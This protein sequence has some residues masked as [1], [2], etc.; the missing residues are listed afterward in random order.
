MDTPRSKHE[1]GIALL[2]TLAFITLA[3]SLAIETNR[4]ARLSIESTDGFQT[5]LV[6]GQM[7]AAGIHGA[8][9][10]LIQDRYASEADHLKETWA[11]P[12]KLKEAL[13]V[14]T[15]ENGQ[16]DVLITDEMGRIQINAL[17]DY[18]QGSQFNPDQQQI[19]ERAIELLRRE[20]DLQS[21]LGPVDMVNAIKDW[22]DTG[23][24]D[25]I[26]GLNGAESDY[27]Q[28]LDPPY[29]TRNG[30]MVHLDE[31]RLVKGISA[32][33]FYGNGEQEGLRD[34][35]TIYGAAPQNE[36]GIAFTGKINLNTAPRLVVAALMP[37]ESSD[38]AE[39]V[40]EYR[41]EAEELVLENVSWYQDVPGATDLELNADYI[42]VVSTIFR[43][44]ATASLDGFQRTV[45]AVVERQAA[46]EGQGWSCR[47]LS[48]ETS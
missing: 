22:L 38:L 16:V 41:D 13:Q 39:A 27:Y 5:R 31:L 15:F 47:I 30:P 23:D 46:T 9:A 35:M 44:R 40:I 12:E 33:L 17:V 11:D 28:G 20:Q 7:A 25:A 19:M 26:T 1:R 32:D 42:M 18:A 14:V 37:P 43:I 45:T 29:K 10:V 8:M 21:D 36:G 34:L 4:M 3:I 2:M 48:W 24:D 6:A